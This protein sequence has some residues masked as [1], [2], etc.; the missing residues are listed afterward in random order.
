[1][2]FLK[3]A[4][5]IAGSIIIILVIIF[6]IYLLVNKQGVIEPLEIG[7]P[8]AAKK[9]LIASQGSE[10]KEALVKELVSYF[11]TT[12]VYVKI[13]DVTVLEDIEESGWDAVV[14]IHTTEMDRLQPDVKAYLDRVQDYGR[15]ILITTSGPGTWKTE[16]YYVDI[17]TSASVKEELPELAEEVKHRLVIMLRD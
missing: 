11:K 16:E 13:V 5:I 8:E 10:F 9:V 14:L 15:V 1:M 6:G 2:K 17:I 12:E 7:Q 3:I 4:L